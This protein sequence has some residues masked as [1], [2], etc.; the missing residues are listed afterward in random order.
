[1]ISD[2][3][4]IVTAVTLREEF[5]PGEEYPV[6]LVVRYP[7]GTPVANASLSVEAYSGDGS[8]ILRENLQADPGGVAHVPLTPPDTG[9]IV[10]NV[11]CIDG[12]GYHGDYSFTFRSKAQ[13]GGFLVWVRSS[14]PSYMVGEEMEITVFVRRPNLSVGS[15]WVYIDI[16]SPLDK[17]TLYT[18][19]A[20]AANGSV[21][22]RI[23][24]LDTYAPYVLV[25]AYAIGPDMEFYSDWLKVDVQPHDTVEVRVETER[26]EYLPGEEC[27]LRLSVSDREGKPVGDCIVCISIVDSSLLALTEQMPGFEEVFYTLSKEYQ[28]IQWEIHELEAEH[29]V[30]S[31]QVEVQR[32][33]SL[34]KR[35]N[36]MLLL[37][38]VAS[39]ALSPTILII[40]G[41]YLILSGSRGRGKLLVALGLLFQIPVAIPLTAVFYTA[42]FRPEIAPL[43]EEGPM[44]LPMAP[45][46]VGKG[47]V[48]WVEE[49]RAGEEHAATGV[50]EVRWFFPETLYWNPSLPVSGHAEVNLVMAHTIT[51]WSVKAIASTRDGRIGVGHGSIRVFKDFFVE[52]DI[53]L[54]LTQDDEVSLRVA[55]YNYVGRSLTVKLRLKHEGWFRL[56][57]SQVKEVTVPGNSVSAV[58]WRI[59]AVS[60]GLHHLTVYAEAEGRTDAVRRQVR[61]SPNGLLLELNR[62]GDLKGEVSEVVYVHPKAIRNATR[63]F[64]RIS[65]GYESMFIGGLEA[66]IGFPGG[67]N[68]QVSSRLI[69]DIL[70][71]S[72][73]DKEGKLTPELRAK[74]EAYAQTGLQTLISRQHPSGGMGWYATDEDNLGMSAWI[75]NTFGEAER[76]GFDIDDTVME[77]LQSWIVEQQDSD[78]SF[79]PVGFYGH[80][81][82]KPDRFVMTG[83][84]LRGLLR[85]GI[86][87]E[88]PAVQRA[89]EYL[90]SRVLSENIED[91]YGLALAVIS[92]KLAEMQDGDPAL[93]KALEGLLSL[94]VEDEDGVHFPKGSSFAGDTENT[95]YAGIALVMAGREHELVKKIVD[96]LVKHRSPG[97]WITTTSDTCGFLELLV[98]ISE[99]RGII[100]ADATVTVSVNG[101]QAYREH[102][103][104][105]TS[106]VE[107]IVLVEGFLKPGL[108][109]VTIKL[110][111][112][113]VFMYQLIVK[114]WLR[115]NLTCRAEAPAGSVNA[116]EIFTVNVTITPPGGDLTPVMVRVSARPQPGLQILGGETRYVTEL[117]EEKT[118]TLYFKAEA[119]GTYSVQPEVAY[120]L[121][122][123]KIYGGNLKAEADPVEIHVEGWTAES[124]VT[125]E[126]RVETVAGIPV[127]MAGI[128]VKVRLTLRNMEQRRLRLV[129]RDQL[130]AGFTPSGEDLRIEGETIVFTITL[131]PG[132]EAS[133]EYEAVGLIPG[134]YIFPGAAV[135][136]EGKPIAVGNPVGITVSDRPI[137]IR[138]ELDNKMIS[139]G[140]T[141]TIKVY[142]A[143]LGVPSL[144]GELPTIN[145]LFITIGLPPGFIVNM[146]SL[147]EAVKNSPY[148]ERFEIH[149]PTRIDFLTGT[150]KPGTV[151]T[152]QFTVQAKYP[153][154]A[155]V[156]P[157]KVQDYYNPENQ[158]QTTPQTV[159]VTQ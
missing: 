22:F 110:S 3:P 70:I 13:R 9:E 54:E 1:M 132:S 101:V 63:A 142:V 48:S 127:T 20:S 84:V 36:R 64:V 113:G 87:S 16:I 5:I 149:S 18:G 59:K 119:Q 43:V 138:R 144:T 35:I 53:P 97:G 37:A 61:V 88:S 130:P 108:N 56:L 15:S 90:R 28:E 99:R 21:V 148:L 95:A 30:S 100:E 153:L 8:L 31:M 46:L 146:T 128:P 129:V 58:Y 75:L 89:L 103:T 82:Y 131:G 34:Q 133:M 102:V 154:K 74:L 72:Y 118:V 49:T 106:D 126:K 140:G 158:H 115:D 117:H 47:A 78:G 156:P 120:M 12:Q 7:D 141:L 69:P 6:Y 55:V 25:R 67:C 139:R 85:S 152:F 40:V 111:G 134:D 32:A 42:F 44:P 57:D 151:F 112:R 105:E 125:V 41:V 77:R 81:S 79:P 143:Y 107:R 124:R 92:F 23:V 76:A 136:H 68:E 73:L 122:Y 116:G 157:A 150:I 29:V 91:S 98:R 135:Y 17:A 121:L 19:S 93:E 4:F 147:E 86:P 39:A 80:G 94:A 62:N 51:T 66:L 65:P 114:Q 10:L 45:E 96:W 145:M 14:R 71:L 104:P 123:G 60:S 24:A 33:E 137:V 50:Q 109:N 27:R 159:V 52:P 26:E 155:T 38:G 83:F 11:G 2:T